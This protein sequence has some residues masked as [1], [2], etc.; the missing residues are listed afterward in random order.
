MR[1]VMRIAGVLSWPVVLPL[2][3]VSRLSDFIFRTCSEALSIVPYAFGIILRREFY[4]WTL[5]R[6]GENVLIGFGT[7][8][9]Y[10][11]WRKDT[12]TL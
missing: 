3:L 9:I 12:T 7:I 10:R 11:D 1:W 2:A 4:K 6:F 8:F 5:T